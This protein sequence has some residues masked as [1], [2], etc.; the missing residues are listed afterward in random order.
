MNKVTSHFDYAEMPGDI[1]Q[2]CRKL[3]SEWG[4]YHRRTLEDAVQIG[5]RLIA[6]RN[7]LDRGLFVRWIESEFGSRSSAYRLI[8]MA[9]GIDPSILPKLGKMDIGTVQ[10]I[11]AAPAA[12]REE[13]LDKI[14]SGEQIPSPGSER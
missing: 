3:L 9:E 10:A 4:A 11:A 7:K 12:A 14:T 13:I 1:A 6:I 2:S 8:Q 5:R